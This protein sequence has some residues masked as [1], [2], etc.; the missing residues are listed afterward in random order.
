MRKERRGGD[1]QKQMKGRA[2]HSMTVSAHLVD[3]VCV[4]GGVIGIGG[5]AAISIADDDNNAV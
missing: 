1:E 2:P 3:V 5:A 4:V